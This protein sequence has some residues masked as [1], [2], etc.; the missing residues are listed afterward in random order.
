MCSCD[1][2]TNATRA[3]SGESAG[4]AK[5]SGPAPAARTADSSVAAEP[6][7]GISTMA[8]SCGT[9][10]RSSRTAEKA[11]LLQGESA[12]LR[13]GRGERMRHATA[14]H[15]VHPPV[16]DIDEVQR[17]VGIRRPGPAAVLV[18]ARAGTPRRGQDLLPGGAAHGD[19]PALRRNALAPPDLAPD[20]ASALDSRRGT[21]RGQRA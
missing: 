3:P 14:R 18:H 11:A 9:S 7:T 1:Q 20:D 13:S 16:G 17:A 19:P 12:E 2:V 10:R 4:C 15:P 5:K 8:R 6:S 21:E